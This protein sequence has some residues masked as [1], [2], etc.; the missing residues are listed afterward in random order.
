MLLS[1]DAL[2]LSFS[3]IWPS[4]I[5]WFNDV[6]QPSCQ[7]PL[8]GSVV[9]M[10]LVA[11]CIH[12]SLDLSLGDKGSLPKGS[13]CL[14]PSTSASCTLALSMGPGVGGGPSDICGCFCRHCFPSGSVV[15]NLPANAGDVSSIPGWGRSP[16]EGNDNPLQYSCHGNP[17]DRGTWWATVH[18]VAKSGTRLND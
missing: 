17:M 18:G 16:G 11:I 4:L 10:A 12:L 14:K 2:F 9:F 3:E 13:C 15:K 7:I 5:P 1:L 6:P 8:L